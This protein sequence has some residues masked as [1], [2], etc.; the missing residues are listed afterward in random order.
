[1]KIRRWLVASTAALGL[2][3]AAPGVA[4][5]APLAPHTAIASKSCSGG[6]THATINGADKCLRRGQFCARA[7]DR[8]Y[9]RLGFHCVS[10]DGRGN[11][12]LS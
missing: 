9:R 2:I 1:M 4:P 11:Y 10:E 8:Q 5:A 6:F 12:H 7:A 3:G